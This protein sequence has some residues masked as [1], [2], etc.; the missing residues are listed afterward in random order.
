MNEQNS[1][2]MASSNNQG[3][4]VYTVEKPVF[5]CGHHCSDLQ[6]TTLK[7]EKTGHSFPFKGSFI[8]FLCVWVFSCMYVYH[9]STW[10]PQ[11]LKSLELELWVV[12]SYHMNTGDQT[13]VL[14]RAKKHSLPLGYLFSLKMRSLESQYWIQECSSQLLFPCTTG[15]LWLAGYCENSKSW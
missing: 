1:K 11:R 3:R 9:R 2:S 14:T 6:A 12:V 13:R 10:C 15:W 8:L 4:A 7:A 5:P